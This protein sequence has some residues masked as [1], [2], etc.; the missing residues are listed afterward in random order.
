MIA[1]NSSAKKS[2]YNE[3]VGMLFDSMPASVLANIITSLLCVSVQ[4]DYINHNVLFSWFGAA[5]LVI[6]IRAAVLTV[7]KH[8]AAE[9]RGPFWG[10]IFSIGSTASGLMLGSSAIFLFPSDI[11]IGQVMCTLVLVG[12]TAGAVSSLSFIRWTFPLYCIGALAPLIIRLGFQGDQLGV[13]LMLMALLS[14][15]FNLRSA[16]YIYKNTT[17]S[18]LMRMEATE[19][20][21]KLQQAIEA[22]E[23]HVKQ[24]PIGVVEWKDDFTIEEWNPACERIFGLSKADVVGIN[25]LDIVI[26]DDFRGKAE[27][28]F[29]TMGKDSVASQDVLSNIN[30]KGEDLICEWNNT[31]L[32]DK[33]G[34]FIGGVSLI[35]DITEQRQV[36]I[37]LMDA[38]EEAERASL[39]KSQ[40]L[41][42]MSH[43]LRTPMNAILGFGQVLES[44]TKEP[45][46][47]FQ[48]NC[49]KHI[50]R[51]GEHL[52]EL[53]DG[54][55]DLAKVEAG[56]V[57]LYIETVRLEELFQ[58]CLTLIDN[59]ARERNLTIKSDFGSRK[60]LNTDYLRLKQVL[61]NL[62]SNAVKYNRKNGSISFVCEETSANIIRISISDTGDGISEDDQAELFKPF[63]RGGQKNSVVEG[64]GIGLTITER[65]TKIMGGEIGFI[66]EVGKGS[67][68]WIE[69][70]V[71]EPTFGNKNTV[72]NYDSLDFLRLNPTNNKILYIEDNPA[73]LELMK[74]I[75][76]MIGNVVL[77]SAHSAELG[78]TLANEVLPDLILMDIDLPGMNGY[79]AKKALNLNEKTKDIP[80]IA[81]TA[82]AMKGDVEK[83]I[84]AG[85]KKYISKPLNVK[86]VLAVLKE[87]M[88]V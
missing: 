55:L 6:S 36:T 1:V 30:T 33:A 57:Q 67:T 4:W 27:K 70:P 14:L 13:T 35:N 15:V 18:I 47:E 74:A 78:L 40:F 38:K 5:V 50:L 53:I 46:S 75:I 31:P 45:L 24:T 83:G 84:K 72:V 34:N 29:G 10:L 63:T 52:L 20:E 49:V 60:Y 69:F 12:M 59:Q 77:I 56:K 8:S 21:E 41:S 58:E 64:T 42:T 80:V 17:Q 71:L 88:G 7:Y 62:L 23:L 3:Q 11:P 86:E 39:A 76:D 82:A 9:G 61:L 37:N 16:N 32:V 73:N 2:V 65:L 44:S 26:A 81:V 51:G 68:F 54:V 19:N 87:E 85:F 48:D 28:I 25:L 66:S 79:E 43:E 22:K